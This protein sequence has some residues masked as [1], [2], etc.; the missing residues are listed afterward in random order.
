MR[1][2]CACRSANQGGRWMQ[3]VAETWFVPILQ[4]V[5]PNL[6][7][8]PARAPQKSKVSHHSGSLW[9]YPCG[10]EREHLRIPLKQSLK[11]ALHRQ[12]CLYV[13]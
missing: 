6:S 7:S 5:W 8:S 3:R 2:V 13:P 4:L 9:R 11:L 10:A 12:M 1:D